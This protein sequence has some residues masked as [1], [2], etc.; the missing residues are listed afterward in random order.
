[1][2]RRTQRRLMSQSTLLAHD[3]TFFDRSQ[4]K[5]PHYGRTCEKENCPP[6][7]FGHQTLTPMAKQRLQAQRHYW[8]ARV[9]HALLWTETT[10][11]TIDSRR[12][13]AG[14]S[15]CTGRGEGCGLVQAARCI[16]VYKNLSRPLPYG[17][18]AAFVRL[19]TRHLFSHTR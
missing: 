11:A 16:F 5:F 6:A 3:R 17:S 9:V 1:M 13:S 14:A 4:K 2:H 7:I 10:L 8:N 18:V 15:G 12:Q 19:G